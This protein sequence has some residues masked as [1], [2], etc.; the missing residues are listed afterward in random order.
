MAQLSNPQWLNDIVVTRRVIGERT[1]YFPRNQRTLQRLYRIDSCKC[2]F[3]LEELPRNTRVVD[4]N[5]N[6]LTGP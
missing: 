5:D 6:I 2:G 3:E 4:E 1:L